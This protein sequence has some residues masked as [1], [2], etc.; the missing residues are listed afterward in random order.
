MNH[1]ASTLTR[2]GLL[3]GLSSRDQSW[4]R[5]DVQPVSPRVT[6]CKKQLKNLVGDCTRAALCLEMILLT[7]GSK[8]FF[9]IMFE[10]QM[11]D[12]YVILSKVIFTTTNNIK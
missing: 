4:G 6:A 7:L 2:H 1:T 3:A 9:K 10:C 8:M 11:S 5:D 12:D